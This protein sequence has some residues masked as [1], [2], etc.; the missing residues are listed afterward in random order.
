[1]PKKL[2]IVRLKKEARAFAAIES[3]YSEP[4]IYGVTDGNALISL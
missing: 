1:M 4:K 3:T 2:P